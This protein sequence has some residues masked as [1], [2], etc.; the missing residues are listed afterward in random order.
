MSH[1]DIRWFVREYRWLSNFFR[2]PEPIK[3]D[4]EWGYISTEHAYMSM[5]S[6]DVQWKEFCRDTEKASVVKTESYKIA[7]RPDWEDIKVDVMRRCLRIKFSQEPLRT[8]LLATE[9]CHIE[10]GNNHGDEYWGVSLETGV[11]K[12]MLGILLMETRNWL[13]R[14][15]KHGGEVDLTSEL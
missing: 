5:K 15:E 14:V 9:N 2:T 1:E 11:G 13:R 3:L 6:N 7:L 4:E 12:N 8:Q 10:E